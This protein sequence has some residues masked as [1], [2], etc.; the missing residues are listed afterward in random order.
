MRKLLLTIFA[1][2]LFI[3]TIWFQGSLSQA[4]DAPTFANTLHSYKIY[5]DGEC[6]A[7]N[8]SRAGT[9]YTLRGNVE[10]N[11]TI[12]RDGIV[13]DG[14]GFTFK[15]KGDS[16][17]VIL[18]DK[19]NVTIKN[20]NVEN[21]E[22]GILLG[23]YSPEAFLWYDPNPN[24]STNCTVN[25]CHVSNNTNGISI[26][27]GIECRIM[28][29]QVTNNEKG[30]TFFGSENVFRNN[31]MKDNGINFADLTYEK[32]DVD[33]SNTING[34]P[35][36]YLINRQNITVPADASMV[37]LEGCSNIIVPNLDINHTQK[38]I[39][40]FNSSNCKIFGNNLGR[41]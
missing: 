34:K 14:S 41:K 3:S 6:N 21:F 31:Q 40:L 5:A 28:G 25:N 13:L 38:A 18:Y 7:P 1:L 2:A 9:I 26:V 32:S 33:S 10:G 19:N 29:N 16:T 11:I 30:I 17:G 23:H 35:I 24:R 20:V 22:T 15:G 8:I 39:S 27:G 12:D 37:H 4:N 36:Y